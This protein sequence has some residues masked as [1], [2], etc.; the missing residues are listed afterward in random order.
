MFDL[1]A[2]T[3]SV[4]YLLR[5]HGGRLDC[6]KLVKLMYL[7]DRQ[8]IKESS[9]SITE[10]DY[11]SL[12]R[13]P[14]ATRLY[15]LLTGGG[16]PPAQ[17][18]WDSLFKREGDDLIA[19][20]DDIPFDW[21]SEH[22]TDILDAVDARFG[23]MSAEEISEWTHNPAN[24]PEWR[25]PHG[26]RLPI[27]KADI[28]KALGFDEEYIAFVIEDDAIYDAEERYLQ[29]LESKATSDK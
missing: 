8:A 17:R 20:K 24:C 26:G 6:G 27:T 11:C 9:S 10:D 4:A 21:L 25:D 23:C 3:Q 2:L 7:A 12:D 15:D 5:K 19:L 16:E 22:N 1:E 29:G 13:G 14:A 18:E 28:M